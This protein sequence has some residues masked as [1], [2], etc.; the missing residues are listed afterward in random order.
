MSSSVLKTKQGINMLEDRLTKKTPPKK[1]KTI[2]PVSNLEQHLPVSWWKSIFN[3]LYLKTDGDVVENTANTVQDIDFVIKLCDIKP[4]DQI[5]DLCCGQGRHTL[6]LASRGFNNLSGIDRSQYLIRLARKRSAG[7]GLKTQFSEGDARKLRLPHSSKDCVIIMGNSFGYFNKEEDDIEVLN[8]VRKVLRTGGKLFLDIVDGSWM[9]KNF[10]KRSWEW[11]DLHHF[12]NRERELAKDG[13]RIISREV[14]VHAEKGVL[15]D[16]FYAERLY[17]KDEICDLLKQLGFLNVQSHGNLESISSRNQD[18]GMMANRL[19]ITAVAPEKHYSKASQI[20]RAPASVLVLLGDPRL[21]DKVKR[22]GKFSQEDL[23]TVSKLKQALNSLK[24]ASFEFLDNHDDLFKKLS[25]RKRPDLILNLCDEGFRNDPLKEPHL[26]AM[27]EMLSI[28]YTGAGPASLGICYRKSM[29]RS[30]AESMDIPVPAE[31][32]Y[33]VSDSAANIPTEFPVLVKPNCGDGSVG[34]TKDALIHSAEEFLSYLSFLNTTLPGQDLLI[35]EFLSGP[36]YSIGVIGN[37]ENL[38]FLPILEV[39][40]SGLPK[41]LPKILS[42][43]SK[44]VPGSPFWTDI[45]YIP[46]RVPDDMVRTL[47]YYAK[48]LFER[49]ECRD[50]ARFDFRCNAEG[51]PMLLEVNPNPGWCWDGKLSLMAGF[52]NTSY[53]ELLKK[54]VTAALQRV[55]CDTQEQLH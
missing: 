41:N 42:Y 16:Q 3:S 54:I 10:E 36:E 39:D 5:L 48:K 13:K 4:E 2:G 35:Q 43:E 15:A 32:F 6:E 52:Q 11:I 37:R 29:V 24:E 50:Y 22:E 47:E 45:K 46:A 7:L 20:K 33:S 34:I 31:I 21:E 28:P 18:L 51:K 8:T 26:P 19:I 12:V 9:S 27:F 30:I 38:E 44:W 53:P 1:L 25:T 17:S 23:D 55:S 14:I 40:Y 49:F